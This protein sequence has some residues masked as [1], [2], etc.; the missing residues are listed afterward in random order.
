MFQEL[1]FRCA[2]GTDESAESSFQRYKI[3]LSEI[4][5]YKFN[6]TAPSLFFI[7]L[8]VSAVTVSMSRVQDKVAVKPH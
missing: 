5:F 8:K 7:H 2:E 3:H 4:W 6:Q 1:I